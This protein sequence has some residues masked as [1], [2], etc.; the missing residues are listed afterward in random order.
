MQL[1]IVL[2][3]AANTVSASRLDLFKKYHHRPAP[4]TK[5]QSQLSVIKKQLCTAQICQKC[6][7]AFVYGSEI[8]MQNKCR[9]IMKIKGCC[10]TQLFIRSR[11]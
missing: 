8:S 1:S 2:I 5:K 11:F 4:I 6:V 7:Q 3:L 9:L 10:P